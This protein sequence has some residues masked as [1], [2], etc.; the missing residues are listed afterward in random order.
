MEKAVSVAY[1]LGD[2]LALAMM[3][4]LLTA[5]G[6]K[7]P[8]VSWLAASIV[9]VLVSDVVYGLGRLDSDWIVGGPID[10]GWIVFYA[11]AGYAALHPSM[12]WLTD[13]RAPACTRV[14]TGGRRLVL[15]SIATLIAPAVLLTE[16]LNGGVVDA[17]VIAAGSA[18]MFLLVM[19]RVGD[20][21]NIRKRMNV[22]KGP[23][24]RTLS[25]LS[26]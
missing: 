15:L 24:P 5:A 1:P 26:R 17:P 8:A 25:G 11:G 23:R 12:I 14:E 2:V 9:G 19:G 21:E 22:N 7:P 3:I 4:R 13:D 16:Y 10:L 6:R 18:L 20:L